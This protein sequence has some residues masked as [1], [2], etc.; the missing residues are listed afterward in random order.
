MLAK[1]LSRSTIELRTEPHTNPKGGVPCLR[2]FEMVASIQKNWWKSPCS[3]HWVCS[4]TAYGLKKVLDCCV[5]SMN[6]QKRQQ[7][8]SSRPYSRFYEEHKIGLS[9][10]TDLIS[11]LSKFVIFNTSSKKSIMASATTYCNALSPCRSLKAICSKGSY[12]L[13][14]SISSPSKKPLDLP[15]SIW[16]G[17]YLLHY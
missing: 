9:S 5:N 2:P 6:A 16:R 1:I 11:A 12:T 13:P 4:W 17:F 14:T 15:L 8:L 3:S 7:P 10:V